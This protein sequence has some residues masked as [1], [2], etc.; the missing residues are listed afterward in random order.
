MNRWDGWSQLDRQWS[1]LREPC[2]RCEEGSA[3]KDGIC[4]QCWLDE[5]AD[6]LHDMGR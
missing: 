3:W 6:Y 5:E 1:D 2:E 4:H